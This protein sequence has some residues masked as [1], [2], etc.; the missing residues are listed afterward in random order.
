MDQKVL[1]APPGF[2]PPGGVMQ[3]GVARHRRA[4]QAEQ[5]PDVEELGWHFLRGRLGVMLRAVRSRLR[6]VGRPTT[7]SPDIWR[8]S[9]GS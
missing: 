5:V 4:H 7:G 3:I 6:Y 2:E 8:R 1:E 9:C